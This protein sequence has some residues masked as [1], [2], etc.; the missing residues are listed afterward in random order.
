MSIIPVNAVH[1]A[2]ALGYG[3][4]LIETVSENCLPSWLSFASRQRTTA[5]RHWACLSENLYRLA[6]DIRG[7]GFRTGD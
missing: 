3:T 5:P 2:L 6:R 4:I 7:I 1:L